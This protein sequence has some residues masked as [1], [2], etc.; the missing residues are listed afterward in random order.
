VIRRWQ[1]ARSYPSSGFLNKLQH[2]ALLTEIVSTTTT[3]SS[4]DSSD[5]PARHERRSSGGGGGGGGG[6]RGGGPDMA[7][8]GR[9]IGGMVGG[10]FGR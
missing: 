6:H 10:M 5:K 4:D 2:K 9:F 3:S 8:P 7:G 1:A